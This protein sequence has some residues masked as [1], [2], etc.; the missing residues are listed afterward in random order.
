MLSVTA[1]ASSDTLTVTVS[2]NLASILATA[3]PWTVLLGGVPRTVVNALGTPPD[4]VRVIVT[5]TVSPFQSLDV[6]YTRPPDTVRAVDNTHLQSG[7]VT[8]TGGPP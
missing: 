4:K 7:N 2:K 3:T 8:G 5:G 6:T 1:P